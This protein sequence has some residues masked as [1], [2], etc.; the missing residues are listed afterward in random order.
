M[1]KIGKLGK[2]NLK[3]GQVMNVL[4]IVFVVLGLYYLIYH[5]NLFGMRM[6]EGLENK[7]DESKTE[8]ASEET[9]E[10]S[11]KNKELND[12]KQ[13]EK[14]DDDDD[15]DKS[16]LKMGMTNLKDMDK[17]VKANKNKKNTNITKSKK[18]VEKTEGF[19][20]MLENMAPYASNPMQPADIP[21]WFLDKTKFSPTCC[22][23]T[24][25]SGTGCA[26]L[27][28]QQMSYLNQRGGNR[29]SASLY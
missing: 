6:Y 28:P 12:E 9:K 18:G 3:W 5:T 20:N 26:C 1:A 17:A 19:H 11:E 10:I 24:Y 2:L 22:P 27:S 25:S 8:S 29:T 7:G 13:D 23:S 4:L 16:T 15:D 14:S 21:N